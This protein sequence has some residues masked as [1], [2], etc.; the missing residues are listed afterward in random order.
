MKST[1]TQNPLTA[2]SPRMVALSSQI[3]SDRRGSVL[4]V[5]I[6]LLSLLLLAGI[7]FYT[8]ASQE[9][10]AAEYYAEAANVGNPLKLSA[11]ELF[12]FGMEQLIL[13]PDSDFT[14]SALR[15]GRAAPG[16]YPGQQIEIPGRHSLIAGVIG[17]DTAVYNGL[18]INLATDT[19][20]MGTLA[21]AYG[22]PY[23]DQDQDGSPDNASL[24]SQLNY[25][26]SANSG[27][28]PPVPLLPAP[29]TG[30]TAP[31]INSPYLAYLG[32]GTDYASGLS[33]DH[34]VI[35][36]TF[37]RPQYLRGGVAAMTTA[38]NGNSARLFRPHPDNKCPNG[39]SRFLN[40][41]IAHPTVASHTVTPFPFTNNPGGGAA[42]SQ[43]V[44]DLSGPPGASPTYVYNWDVDND[45]DGIREGV[46]LDLDY[47]IQDLA[48]G[49][50]FVPMFSFTVVDSDGLINLNASG[51]SLAWMAPPGGNPTTPP[52]AYPGTYTNF[53]HRSNMGMSRTEINPLW[54]LFA[55]GSIDPS[56]NPVY[57]SSDTTRDSALTQM[58]VLWQL[59][60]AGYPATS[61]SRLDTAN[62]DYLSL[63]LGRVDFAR[64]RNPGP[65][66]YAVDGNYYAASGFFPGRRGE[67]ALLSSNIAPVGGS[68]TTF[69]PGGIPLPGS[70]G[71]DDDNDRYATTSMVHPIDYLGTGSS[72]TV[73]AGTAVTQMLLGR[74]DNANNPCRWPA[75]NGYHNLQY[76]SGGNSVSYISANAGSSFISPLTDMTDEEDEEVVDTAAQS[77][78]LNSKDSMFGLAEMFA[79]HGSDTDYLAT[80]SSSRLRSLAHFNFSDN[81]YAELIRK[82]YTV[83]SMDRL[84]FGL[85]SN[86][87][88]TSEANADLDSDGHFEFPPAA[89]SSNCGS[90]A[91]PIRLPLRQYLTVE[92]GS[93]QLSSVG[94]FRL[95]M[96]KLVWTTNP[97]NPLAGQTYLRDLTYHPVDPGTSDVYSTYTGGATAYP[98]NPADPI[99]MEWW[100]RH[101]RQLLARDIYCLLYILGGG[102]D[103]A[104]YQDAQPIGATPTADSNAARGLYSDAQLKEMA[105]FAVNYVDAL[106]F[107][108]HITMFE[109]DRDLGDGWNLGDDPYQTGD[110]N[111]GGAIGANDR[112][113]VYGVETQSLTLAEG[114]VIHTPQLVSDQAGATTF[115]DTTERWYT[116]LELRNAS[117]FD[118]DL[119]AKSWRIRIIDQAL[120]QEPPLAPTIPSP[121]RYLTF[122]QG[123]IGHGNNFL[124]GSRTG[125][126][127]DK[128]NNARPS[129][130]RVNIDHE[131]ETPG[132][133]RYETI[134][135]S[136]NSAVLAY[137]TAADPGTH[138]DLDLVTQNGT[139]AFDLY[140]DSTSVTVTP[141]GDFVNS[142][143]AGTTVRFVIERRLHLT[144]S[145]LA[146]TTDNPWIEVDRM[147]APVKE[148]NITAGMSGADLKTMVL[149]NLISKERAQPF[150]RNSEGNNTPV[151]ASPHLANSFGLTANS[152]TTSAFTNWQP[153][154][155]RPYTSVI[156]LLTLPLF[157]PKNFT[158][159]FGLGVDWNTNANWG[160][161]PN[162]AQ[163]RF[164]RTIDSANMQNRWYR[165]LGLLGV[166][167]RSQTTVVQ[168]P[169]A[170]RTPGM[171]NL[172]TMRDRGVFN[173]LVDDI[174]TQFPNGALDAT[175]PNTLVGHMNPY[176]NSLDPRTMCQDPAG[177]YNG[178]QRDWWA[179]FLAAR[180]QQ[181]PITQLYLPGMAHSRPYRSMNYT[182]SGAT[183]VEY[184]LLRG[185]VKD[186]TAVT[187]RG[188]FEASR[189]LNTATDPVDFHTRHRLLRKVAN[190]ST[191]RSNVFSVWVS[192]GL[193]EAVQQ[194]NGDVQIGGPINGTGVP[195]FRG[196]FVVDRSLPEQGLDAASGQFDFDQFIKYRKTIR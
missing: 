147:D 27:T 72:Y 29:D 151:A 188:V 157:G 88:R 61:I 54:G 155:N 192:V 62:M 109:Y 172:N 19:T 131:T 162:F 41:S 185:M 86:A 73:G 69:A 153:H 139:G 2:D 74:A 107:D 190:N 92:F 182:D 166:P 71:F 96:N 67:T 196:F 152:N 91:E 181:D 112:A 171:I 175:T 167:S 176:F 114:L 82:Q 81:K 160:T 115:N 3:D 21:G 193:F 49:R 6:G 45:G 99:A 163:E 84:Q 127:L 58:R 95:N 83:M 12:A 102:S 149:P 11:D 37:H 9:N 50:S 70:M 66:T 10:S 123:S 135:P 105:Q 178:V 136:A 145:S 22:Y 75:Y 108:D 170:L 140:N 116:A 24:L 20:P 128:D 101:D 150:S 33:N 48:D 8:F 164:L 39:S 42:I 113:V 89:V 110:D 125:T 106:D 52:I 80:S 46:W 64:A 173:G 142:G 77:V 191:T 174:S 122:K 119:T 103:S 25:S 124:I 156:D 143:G 79:L 65:G 44:W 60:S 118:V 129:D 26:A 5:V 134:V 141:P 7:A 76:S 94:G 15:G 59:P 1:R 85:G 154:F 32:Y 34:R 13:G 144:R 179:E 183:S 126:D 133:Y 47:P 189:N 120:D 40:A 63:L 36:P 100:A 104:I 186:G 28:A 184:T 87:R 68:V 130:F 148:F 169:Y 14:M 98:P 111:V 93:N 35:I 56:S 38:G 31:D 16:T 43:G 4:L 165:L 177:D 51:N 90:P 132:D 168:P 55:D 194:P 78:A 161:T 195:T 121:E 23:V 146:S 117:A 187:R 138:F 180:N 97:A 30:Y 159:Q 57:F 137:E 53:V 18:G 17:N 158:Q